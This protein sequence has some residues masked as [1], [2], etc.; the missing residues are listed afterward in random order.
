[1]ISEEMERDF[2]VERSFSSHTNS[3]DSTAQIHNFH[4]EEKVF[5]FRR[6]EKDLP[7]FQLFTKKSF[8]HSA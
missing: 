5:L 1:M 6:N 8:S 3:S 7:S 2:D 4:L